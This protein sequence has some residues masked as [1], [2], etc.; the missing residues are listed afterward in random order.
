MKLRE[1]RSDTGGYGYGK[2]LGIRV[3]AN[4]FAVFS[5]KIRV[6]TMFIGFCVTERASYRGY[7]T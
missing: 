7:C 6:D 4:N 3:I 2:Y 5:V 1:L